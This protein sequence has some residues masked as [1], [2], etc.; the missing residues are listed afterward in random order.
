MKLL[1][2]LLV[3]SSCCT[4]PQA[5]EQGEQYLSEAASSAPEAEKPGEQKLQP[6]GSRKKEVRWG[7]RNKEWLPLIVEVIGG[8]VEWVVE[9]VV[10]VQESVTGGEV[11]A[12]WKKHNQRVKRKGVEEEEEEKNT[13]NWKK[14]E[15]R[16]KNQYKGAEAKVSQVE[17]MKVVGYNPMS[18]TS[19]MRAEMISKEFREVEAI[20]LAGTMR[21]KGDAAE[22][23]VVK[24]QTEFHHEIAFGHERTRYSNR[25]CGVSI[26]LSKEKYKITDVVQVEQPKAELRGRM[27][28][29]RIK[30]K[31]KDIAYIAAY[32]PPKIQAQKKKQHYTQCVLKMCDQL[33]QWLWALPKRCTP[34]VFCDLNDNLGIRQVPED[35]V[36]GEVEKDAQ[37][38]VEAAV[39]GKWMAGQ[40]GI[41]GTQFRKVMT[42]C[43]MKVLNT[44]Y[45]ECGDTY[46]G[47]SSQSRID[48]LAVPQG[49]PVSGTYTLKSSGFRLQP[50][51]SNMQRDHVPVLAN[52]WIEQQHNVI[53]KT[54]KSRL[55]RD[56]LMNS[57]VKGANKHE[58]YEEVVSELKK[59]QV[60]IDEAMAQPGPDWAWNLINEVVTEVTE[61][62]Y[63]KVNGKDE[64]QEE[65]RKEKQRLL[66]NRFELKDEIRELLTELEEVEA[67]KLTVEVNQN[68]P[69]LESTVWKVEKED[70]NNQE[71]IDQIEKKIAEVDELQKKLA[72][73]SF[74]CRQFRRQKAAVRKK[75][76]VFEL[77]LLMLLLLPLLL[78]LLLLLLTT[79]S[80][81]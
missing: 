29:V 5:I 78:L 35:E 40:E 48:F 27:G 12:G 2:V 54:D 44:H 62:H 73:N 16:K 80:T 19:N 9:E 45:R 55:D 68:H 63:S 34:I 53:K 79:T 51:T 30:T 60:E 33:E 8:L 61:K 50:F 47:T 14:S 3:I 11:E 67:K 26:M 18:L 22:G 36:R 66:Q 64:E 71:L 32:Y 46:Y 41:A 52:M 57:L 49:V 24:L 77:M 75:Q 25:S 20:M 21:K 6:D 56:K 10:L 17:T 23:E 1:I 15:E 65:A 28:M 13:Q 39:I 37:D 72:V 59:R 69:L 43:Q 74:R 31:T 81:Q 70:G 42:N 38:E 76:L 7:T 4:A 58:F